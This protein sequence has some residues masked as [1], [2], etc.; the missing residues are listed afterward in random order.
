MNNPIFN[1]LAE[2]ITRLF[3]EKPKFFQTL[4]MIAFAAGGL[5][6]T[7]IYLQSTYGTL[8]S[9]VSLIGNI[10]VVVASVV[11]LIMAQLPNKS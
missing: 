4:Q 9:W 2:F 8:P 1:F 10:N 6:T 7:I 11:A 5:S 3:S